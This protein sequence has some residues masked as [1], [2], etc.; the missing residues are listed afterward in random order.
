L[1]RFNTQRK[2]SVE[3]R[4]P[5]D[6]EVVVQANRK[7]LFEDARQENIENVQYTANENVDRGAKGHKDYGKVPKYL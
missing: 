3:V 4:R 2:S 1:A 7:E 5:V 6:P